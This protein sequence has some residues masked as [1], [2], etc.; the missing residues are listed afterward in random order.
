MAPECVGVRGG[1]RYYTAYVTVPDASHAER[2]Q[3]QRRWR[4][5]AGALVVAIALVTLGATTVQR[6]T[7]GAAEFS[8]KDV[9]EAAKAE[10]MGELSALASEANANKRPNIVR[11]Q[12]LAWLNAGAVP[13]DNVF[14]HLC[15]RET[16]DFSTVIFAI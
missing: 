7:S 13:D 4:A 3:L 5:V 9:G 10:Q 8:E 6:S 11:G 15:G 16:M 14:D 1:E 12:K 2:S